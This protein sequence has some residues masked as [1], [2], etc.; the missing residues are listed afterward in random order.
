ME[1]YKGLKM[2]RK[3]NELGQFSPGTVISIRDRF[4]SKVEKTKSCW[5]W[6]GAKTGNGYGAIKVNGKMRPAHRVSY[7]LHLGPIP[8]GLIVLHKCDNPGCVRPM[9]LRAGTHKDNTA[10]MIRKN[11][12]GVIDYRSE[13]KKGAAVKKQKTLNITLP[14]VI[15]DIQLLADQGIKPTL[16]A[17]LGIPGYSTVLKY[18]KHSKLI[19]MVKGENICAP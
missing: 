9:H 13:Q 18:F 7:E 6:V 8:D 11:R 16:R 4:F 3:R 5:L 17:C 10:D 19:S 1:T 12:Q 14:K 2:E 15:S